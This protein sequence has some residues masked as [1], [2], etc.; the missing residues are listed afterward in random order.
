MHLASSV[1]GTIVSMGMCDGYGSED[2]GQTAVS[3]SFYHKQRLSLSL[4]RESP[5]HPQYIISMQ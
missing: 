1:Y 4:E 2:D 3:L 5:H